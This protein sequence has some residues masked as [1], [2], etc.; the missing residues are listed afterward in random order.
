MFIGCAAALFIGCLSV[1]KRLEV[2]A[3][4]RP[5]GITRARV[6]KGW[7]S[8]G[9]AVTG[10]RAHKKCPAGTRR[11]APREALDPCQGEAMLGQA[12]REKPALRFSE[13]SGQD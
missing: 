12:L 2:R 10:I 3:L 8:P 6:H 7:G 4:L 5:N 11:S 13:C 9:L 1:P